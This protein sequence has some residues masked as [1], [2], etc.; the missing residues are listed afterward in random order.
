MS[1]IPIY[2]QIKGGLTMLILVLGLVK[3][4]YAQCTYKIERTDICLLK[5]LDAAGNCSSNSKTFV[6]GRDLPVSLVAFTQTQGAVLFRYIWYRPDGQEYSRFT[7]DTVNAVCGEGHW[8]YFYPRLISDIPEHLGEWK[9]D[10]LIS[11]NGEP[12]KSVGIE[13]FRMVSD[14]LLTLDLG[15]AEASSNDEVLIPLYARNF[16]DVFGLQYSIKLGSTNAEIV[17]LVP[18]PT[19]T[20]FNSRKVDAQTYGVIWVSE[21]AQAVTVPDS[22]VI[23]WIKV[24]LNEGFEEGTCI[25]IRIEGTPTDLIAFQSLNG[26]PTEIQP[27]VLN[28]EICIRRRL[29]GEI[30]GTITYHGAK[31][32][33]NAKVVL[34]P[35]NSKGG[36]NPVGLRLNI[37][38]ASS[39][40]DQEVIIPITVYNFRAV[41]GIQGVFKLLVRDAE[42]VSLSPLHQANLAANQEDAQSL[43][44][45]WTS[46]KPLTLSD[47]TILMYLQV[48]VSKNAKPN[49]CLVIAAASDPVELLATQGINGV[50][51]TVTPEI[52]PGVIGLGNVDCAAAAGLTQTTVSNAQ[53]EYSFKNLLQGE[54]YQIKPTYS[55]NHRNGVNVADLIVLRQH[56]LNQKQLND[57][58]LLVAG[59]IDNSK[60]ITL[61][62]LVQIQRLILGELDSFQG[63]PAWRF[64][65]NAYLQDVN[66][67]WVDLPYDFQATLN[68]AVLKVD[69]SGIKL[70]DL[71]QSAQLRSNES[72][73]M[74]AADLAF[75]AGQQLNSHLRVDASGLEGFQFDLNFDPSILSFQG[76]EDIGGFFEFKYHQLEAGRVSIV[77]Y[78]QPSARVKMLPAEV[79]FSL[80]LKALKFGTLAQSLHLNLD[81][82][83]AI[84]ITDGYESPLELA[85]VDNL[86]NTINENTPKQ[87]RHHMVPNP[88]VHSA[89]L[90]VYAPRSQELELKIFDAQGRTMYRK[91]LNCQT[92]ENRIPWMNE[93]SVSSGLFYYQLQGK[94]VQLNGKFLVLEN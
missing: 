81:R 93:S 21:T 72:R 91:L 9:V 27:N 60:T 7:L 51:Q 89:N 46:D 12:F 57:A 86:K 67:S 44:F 35:P 13:T 75:S 54:T 32:F 58:K 50:E 16:K 3:S 26:E 84:A 36:N 80:H 74:K 20:A 53:G 30:Q 22:T 49:N 17:E 66:K 85:F 61:S 39:D 11:L 29:L 55:K 90:D 71:T 83:P 52:V 41:S 64:V 14:D 34:S 87:W 47:G 8:Y 42:L 31:P 28:G 68:A 6:A 38:V 33:G 5:N 25:P 1:N 19:I 76:I 77:A 10:I 18:T 92:G 73:I 94:D 56:L 23:M 70:G 69:F 59:D 4:S 62:D 88:V 45:I 15:E 40:L 43:S 78:L 2:N 82:I 79:Q 24:K 37:G 65:A 48:K 63:Q